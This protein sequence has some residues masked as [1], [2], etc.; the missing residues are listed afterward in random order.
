[1]GVIK[2]QGIKHSIVQFVGIGLSAIAMIFVY[3]LSTFAYGLVQTLIAAAS[4]VSPF[5]LL[6]ITVVSV[7][8]FPQFRNQE[9][10]HNGF[11]G[12]MMLVGFIGFLAFLLAFP[13][14]KP[15]IIDTFFKDQTYEL[16]NEFVIL[17]LP[18]ILAISFSRI[19]ALHASNFQRIVVPVILE[20]T[21]IRLTLPLL[22]LGYVFHYL[23]INQVLFGVILTYAIGCIGLYFYLYK[24]GQL[25][26]KPNP[27][28][29]PVPKVKEMAGYGAYGILSGIGTKTA[30]FI[31]TLMVSALI[32]FNNTGVYAI[33]L[34]IAN[35]IGQPIRSIIGI[36]QPIISKAYAEN[37]LEEIKNHLSKIFPKP[38]DFR[39]FSIPGNLVQPD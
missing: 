35:T 34:F 13:L 15:L 5:V 3:N 29:Y 17:L 6:G 16:A 28:A 26:L 33:S 11:L 21:L 24:L 23:G 8:Y 18:L 9:N 36:A 19:A 20:E 2:R 32:D 7:K 1:M 37:N 30:F 10:G 4:F 25:K 14:L 39:R 27:E 22:I 12:I 31:D 38:F